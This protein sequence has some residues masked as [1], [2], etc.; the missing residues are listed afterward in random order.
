MPRGLKELNLSNNPNL[1]QDTYKV[2]SEEVLESPA[3]KMEKLI[4][5]GC[6]INDEGVRPLARALEYN[7]S[8]KY[9][10]LSKNFIRE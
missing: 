3:C 2:L 6:K 1:H 4:L 8:L 7:N 10:D 5:E 9:L